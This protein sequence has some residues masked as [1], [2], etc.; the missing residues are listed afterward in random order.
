M[1]EMLT[2]AE[3][4]EARRLCKKDC[5]LCGELSGVHCCDDELPRALDTIEALRDESNARGLEIEALKNLLLVES[6]DNERLEQQLDAERWRDAKTEKPPTQD[7]ISEYVLVQTR[8]GT[9]AIACID[10]CGIW[11]NEDGWDVDDVTRWRAL[12]APPEAPPA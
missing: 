1:S 12:A 8:H 3:C 11:I 2:P 6:A 7:G 10:L 5:A 9:T 4:Q